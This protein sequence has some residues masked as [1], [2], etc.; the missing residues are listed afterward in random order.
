MQRS[1]GKCSG[2]WGRPGKVRASRV[3]SLL[4]LAF[5][6]RPSVPPQ[7]V[8][9]DGRPAPSDPAGEPVAL[10]WTC[11]GMLVRARPSRRPCP[12][13]ASALLLLQDARP[14]SPP[15]TQ[16][17]EQARPVPPPPP[18][19]SSSLVSPRSGSLSST[20]LSVISFPLEALNSHAR[21]A[22]REA[23]DCHVHDAGAA[24]AAVVGESAKALRAAGV[25][26]FLFLLSCAGTG[27][28]PPTLRPRA[29]PGR[30]GPC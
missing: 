25:V 18:T 15:T 17:G 23:R 8:R 10:P 21:S 19:T 20:G 13:P 24:A 14:R 2:G 27:N 30:A 29:G 4:H 9:K 1:C 6:R 16:Q 5:G 7:A 12:R 22:T 3:A 11:S 26:L 28:T